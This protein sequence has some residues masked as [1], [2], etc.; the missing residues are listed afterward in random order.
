MDPTVYDTLVA[1]IDYADLLA[2]LGAAF[3]AILAAKLFVAGGRKILN[4]ASRV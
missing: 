2:A 4:I 1:G 3:V